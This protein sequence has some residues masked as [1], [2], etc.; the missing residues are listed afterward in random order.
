MGIDYGYG[1]ISFETIPILQPARYICRENMGSIEV[2]L[3]SSKGPN[4]S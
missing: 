1:L 2:L 3:R 4:A